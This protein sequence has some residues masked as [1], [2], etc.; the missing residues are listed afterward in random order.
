MNLYRVA[1]M[2]RAPQ[3]MSAAAADADLHNRTEQKDQP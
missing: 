2:T 3:V 1:S